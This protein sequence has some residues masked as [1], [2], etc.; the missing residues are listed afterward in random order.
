MDLTQQ[1]ITNKEELVEAMKHWIKYDTEISKMN[2]HLTK[3][4]KEKKIIGDKLI[5][6]F[7]KEEQDGYNVGAG[8]VLMRKTTTTKKYNQKV[9]KQMICCYFNDN[10]A[11]IKEFEEKT[12][13]I[14]PIITKDNIVKKQI[15]G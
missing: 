13:H 14:I 8:I 5:D 1:N 15:E 12:Q 10:E 4:R 9:L 2:K 6:Y 11:K 3:I 7:K